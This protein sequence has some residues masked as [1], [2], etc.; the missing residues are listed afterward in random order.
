[1]ECCSILYIV[2]PERFKLAQYHKT[3]RGTKLYI[4][5]W[6]SYRTIHEIKWYVVKIRYIAEQYIHYHN[7]TVSQLVGR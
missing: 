2:V 7:L 1:M 5:K 6:Y 3:A 4:T